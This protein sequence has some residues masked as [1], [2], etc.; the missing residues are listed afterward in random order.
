MSK[1]NKQYGEQHVMDHDKYTVVNWGVKHYSPE[2]LMAFSQVTCMLCHC[3]VTQKHWNGPIHGLNLTF[4]F[5]H[6]EILLSS[7]I[8]NTRLSTAKRDKHLP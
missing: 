3:T 5:S 1:T 2:M 6:F 8:S 7:Q 4:F